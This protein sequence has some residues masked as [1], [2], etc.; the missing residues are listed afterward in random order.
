[1]AHEE[2]EGGNEMIATN[3]IT[4]PSHY[5]EGRKYEPRKVINDWGLDFYKGNA[6]K[7]ISRAGR[8][9]DKDKEIEDLE[10]AI[11]YLE[12]EIGLITGEED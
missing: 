7:Y 6:L 3:D 4:N 8:K 9:G 1:M 2:S 10:K 12:F 5:V 11:Q